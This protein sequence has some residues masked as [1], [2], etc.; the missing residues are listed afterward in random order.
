MDQL[1]QLRS[2]S[3][4]VSGWR[5]WQLGPAPLGQL[6]SL[7]QRGFVWPPGR[8]QVARCAD[9]SWRS[10]GT[11]EAE[12]DH[13]APETDCGCGVHASVDLASL[14][15]QALCL[16]PVPLVIG[17]VALWGRVITEERADRRGQ[18]HRGQF[19]YPLHLWVVPE[20]L[21]GVTEAQAVGALGTY[22]VAVGVM[23]LEE[24]VGEVSQTI[25]RHLSMSTTT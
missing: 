21:G 1:D 25:L 14:Q 22:G 9:G 10:G 5:Y 17:Q 19:A 6:R 4:P 11:A 2:R 13:R 15:A 18:D 16:R 23:A 3:E 20:T 7:S 8:A 24:A 12:Q